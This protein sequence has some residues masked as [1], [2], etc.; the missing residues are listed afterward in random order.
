MLVLNTHQTDY[1]TSVAVVC[2]A[3]VAAWGRES[4]IAGERKGAN[5]HFLVCYPASQAAQTSSH[6]PHPGHGERGTG[7]CQVSGAGY[8]IRDTGLR[9]AALRR[10]PLQPVVGR[11]LCGRL[12]IPLWILWLPC[13]RIDSIAQRG[14]HD[15]PNDVVHNDEHEPEDGNPSRKAKNAKGK[16]ESFRKSRGRDGIPLEKCVEILRQSPYGLKDPVDVEERNEEET[17]G[18]AGRCPGVAVLNGRPRLVPEYEHENGAV[19]HGDQRK[20]DKASPR[21]RGSHSDPHISEND[22]HI[23]NPQADAD[24]TQEQTF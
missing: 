12:D 20:T 4:A 17:D 9:V 5:G 14:H 11:S 18:L 19:Q 24:G 21:L 22:E 15:Q 6:Y 1:S 7:R 10:V 16:K 3:G 13:D 2:L 23:G 8:G